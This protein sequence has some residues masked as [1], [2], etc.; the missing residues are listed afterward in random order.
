MSA[1]QRARA[2]D[3]ES[4]FGPV[5]LALGEGTP[6]EQKELREQHAADPLAAVEF[7]EVRQLFERVRALRIEP[8]D[9]LRAKLDEV[10]RQS[11]RRQRQRLPTPGIGPQ[12]AVLGA[13]A[14]ACF[15]LLH[16]L[17]PLGLRRETPISQQ[18][19]EAATAPEPERH[20]SG[21][22]PA[23]PIVVA[24]DAARHLLPDSPLGEAW[25]RY[26]QFLQ[27][28]DDDPAQRFS[29][30]VS[31]R[32]AV[33]AL[34]LDYELRAAQQARREALGDDQGG[35]WQF[36][37]VDDRVR[38][39][40]RD[41]AAGL[42]RGERLSAAELG[43][44]VRA[45]L[46]AGCGHDAALR[47]GAALLL[48]ELP[49]LDGG[50]L[51]GALTALGEYAVATGEHADE[52]LAHGERLIAEI[53]SEETWLRRRPRLLS[54]GTPATALADAGRFLALAPAFGVDADQAL[55]VRLMLVAHLHERRDERT[56]TADTLAALAYGFSDLLTQAERSGIDDRLLTWRP[57]SLLPDY[58]ALHQL[59][60]SRT[61]ANT[62]YARWQLGL[63]RLIGL[64]TPAG[65]RDRASL[66]LCFAVNFG[67]D[68]LREDEAH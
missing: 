62:G 21:P 5:E 37:T 41:V 61:P 47:R 66:C 28:R 15:L 33:A 46:A 57:L 11:R 31:P 1:G 68:R 22:G 39:L 13:A 43:P 7:A 55:F 23:S 2:D 35:A 34:R 48:A 14:A 4:R 45:L 54:A 12:L 65:L 24:W 60:A 38:L 52:V 25:E 18:I 20:P 56:E 19:A 42:L 36:A 17:D 53:V 26:Q 63:R 10:V 44:A 9:R 50:A 58:E 6:V 67:S 32:N 49:A 16:L 40:A 59:A 3:Q 27:S 29:Q 51:A 8:G 64:P 30:W